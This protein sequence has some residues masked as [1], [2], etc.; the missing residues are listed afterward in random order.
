[1]LLQ[2]RPPGHRFADAAL[3]GG[4]RR[5][6]H[7]LHAAAAGGDGARD[8]FDA[9]PAS[10]DRMQCS[11]LLRERTAGGDHYGCTSLL[12]LA[13]AAAVKSSS[14]LPDGCGGAALGRCLHG[15]AVRVRYADGAVVAKAVMDMYGRIGSLADTCMV[16]DEMS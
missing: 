8:V 7:H 13:L 10:D 12:R 6:S 4:R 16:F 14:A 1:M 5:L 2:A 15:L 9:V 3:R 11:V